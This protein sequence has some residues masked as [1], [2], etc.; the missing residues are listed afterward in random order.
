MI[1]E[2][3]STIAWGSN[4]LTY[5][6]RRSARRKKTVALKVEPKGGVLV[7][8]P[9]DCPTDEID[10]IVT[11]KAEWIMQKLQLLRE[12]P[13]PAAPRE[14]AT[15]ESVSYL[16][17]QYHLR[18]DSSAPGEARL[19]G[20]WIHVPTPAGSLQGAYARAALIAWFQRQ[21]AKRIK[22]RVEFWRL[23]VGVPMP[24][25]VIANQRKRW[26]SCN[27]H[28]AIRLN[29][30]LVQAPMRLI[31]YVV[32]HELVHILHQNHSREYWQ[33]VGR[34]LPDYEKRREE[35]KRLGG[36]FFW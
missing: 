15:G 36:D 35:L 10:D 30:R 29:W 31:D 2:E 32:V 9:A 3:T 14:F 11:R 33:A 4:L 16:G 12:T 13:A 18:I 27:R 21:A 17:R 24:P 19:A 34:V 28:G 23:R 5:T 1:T 26:G 6:I 25:V 8:A 7:L 22:E 20:E